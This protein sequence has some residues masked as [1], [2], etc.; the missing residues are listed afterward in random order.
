MF[1]SDRDPAPLTFAIIAER[2]AIGP[3]IAGATA[4][5]QR[6]GAADQNQNEWRAVKGVAVAAAVRLEEEA[7][8]R[9]RGTREAAGSGRGRAA[10]DG[11]AAEG[12]RG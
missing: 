7:I 6:D 11:E 3:K 1:S 9:G 4:E 2:R 8:L 5:E 10:T 12:S